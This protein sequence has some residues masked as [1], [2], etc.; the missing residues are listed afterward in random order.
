MKESILNLIQKYLQFLAR[1][2]IKRAKPKII[3]ITGSYG[4]TSAKEA[5]Y[6]VLNKKF[7]T[8]VG[9][10]WGNMNSVLGLPLAIL[11]LRKYSFGFG[12]L[13]NIIQAKWNFFF[14]KLP[15]ILVLEMG[16]DKPGEMSQLLS[17]A[18]PDIAIITGIS[19]THL[20]GL[21]N[22]EG[23]KK[24]KNLLFE[25]LGKNG[26]AII[27]AG[28][29]NSGDLKIPD[30]VKK[31]TFGSIDADISASDVEVTTG[32]TDFELNIL[33][34]KVSIKSKLIGKHSIQNLLIAAVVA[35]QFGINI[36][37]IKVLL[38]QIKPQNGRMKIIK[39]QNQITLIDDSYNS[40][41]KSAEEALL[42]LS[43]IKHSGR[44]IAILGNMNELG[45][46]SEEAHIRVGKAAGKS[47]DLFIATGDN[48]DYLASGAKESGMDQ[49]KIIKFG[50]TEE[51]IKKID[52]VIK[53]EDLILIKGS[54][55]RVR[56]ERLVKYL[57][58]DDESA[59]KILVRQEKKWQD[60]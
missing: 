3:V 36:E 33:G 5:V 39:I 4:K 25:T 34:K 2:K 21:K 49:D 55:N 48:A 56:L 44:K 35:D 28:D 16:I 43:A 9:K 18:K 57:V 8:D 22:L 53:P 12:L 6:F 52:S 14:Y 7:G 30:G 19:E 1:W 42:A 37:E 17:V 20:E 31:L 40:N 51:L 60:K 10:N 11:G 24:E 45:S 47:V 27:N 54:Q 59:K 41:P 26:V 23:V 58:N 46:Y 50:S 32:G 15:K 38:E 29:E 13:W